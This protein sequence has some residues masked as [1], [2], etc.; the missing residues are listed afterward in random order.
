MFFL[1]GTLSEK[2]YVE[3]TLRIKFD[4]IIGNFFRLRKALYG[5][6]QEARVWNEILERIILDQEYKK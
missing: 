5:L 2:I 3:V 1:N 4:P 6:K